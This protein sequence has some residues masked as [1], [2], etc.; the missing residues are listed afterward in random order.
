MTLTIILGIVVAVVI[1]FLLAF[2]YGA[3]RLAAR[4][5]EELERERVRYEIHNSDPDS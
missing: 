4:A 3:C 5:D 1:G 2:V